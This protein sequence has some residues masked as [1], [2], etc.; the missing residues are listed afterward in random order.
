MESCRMNSLSFTAI[1][2]KILLCLT[3]IFIVEA[4]KFL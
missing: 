3:F 4:L 1:L 2:Q